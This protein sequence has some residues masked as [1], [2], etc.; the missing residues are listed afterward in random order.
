MQHTLGLPTA[1][2]TMLNDLF[3]LCCRSQPVCSLLQITTSTE[4][5]ALQRPFCILL[6]IIAFTEIG[7]MQRLG[8]LPGVCSGIC[9]LHDY[10]IDK[11]GIYL[12][13]TRYTCSLRAWLAK[14]HAAPSTRLKLYLTIFCQLA[15]VLQVMPPPRACQP[16]LLSLDSW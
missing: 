9:K 2:V 5:K 8:K 16:F 6:Q 15:E 11:H 12:V 4:I 14:Q 10:G 3:V 7:A 13:M 1:T